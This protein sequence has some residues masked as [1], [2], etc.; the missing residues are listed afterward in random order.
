MS[1]PSAPVPRVP[2]KPRVWIAAIPIALCVGAIAMAMRG[3]IGNGIAWTVAAVALI[4]ALAGGYKILARRADVDFYDWYHGPG[5]PDRPG[6][7]LNADPLSPPTPLPI[8]PAL[9]PPKPPKGAERRQRECFAICIASCLLH[10]PNRIQ[11]DTLPAKPPLHSIPLRFTHYVLLSFPPVLSA[12]SMV[13]YPAI[14]MGKEN[15]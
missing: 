11:P 8:F 5:N 15:K 9:K 2:Q 7:P 14:H 4:F 12:S 13:Q 10:S 1:L 6:A 3:T